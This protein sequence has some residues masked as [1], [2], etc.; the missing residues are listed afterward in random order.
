MKLSYYPYTLKLKRRFKISSNSRLTT[1]TVMVEIEHGGLI[2]YGEASLPPYLK[3]DQQSVIK[4]LQEVK[5]KNFKNEEH[6]KTAIQ[7]LDTIDDGNNAAKASVDIALHDLMGKILNVSLSTYLDIPEKNELYSSYTIGISDEPT[8]MRKLDEASQFKFLKI[9]LGTE[10]D[11]KLITMIRS[12]TDK[13]IYVDVNQ[14][15][16]DKYFALDMIEFLKEQNVILV[17]QPLAKSSLKDTA[18]LTEKSTL[19]II[20]DEDVQDLNDQSRWYKQSSQNV[21]ESKRVELENNAWLY[22]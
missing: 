17:E 1:P 20:A 11:K 2:G 18:W 3:E 14:G 6:F 10:D 7:S 5:L 9:K 19:P 16:R 4:F 13:Q 21:Y 22:D 8:L 12:L 15:W